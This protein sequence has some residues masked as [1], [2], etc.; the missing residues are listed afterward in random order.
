MAQG[1]AQSTPGVLGC[2]LGKK[3]QARAGVEPLA[4][5]IVAAGATVKRRVITKSGFRD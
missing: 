2:G 5:V 1:A 4:A 3:S